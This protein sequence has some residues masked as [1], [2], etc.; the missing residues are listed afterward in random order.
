M[1]SIT[2]IKLI[3]GSQALQ[4]E[5]AH[6]M[7]SLPAYCESHMPASLSANEREGRRQPAILPGVSAMH[8]PHSEELPH[9]LSPRPHHLLV[10]ADAQLLA[11]DDAGALGPGLVLVVGVLLQVNLAEARLLLI[12]R[13]FLLVCHGLPARP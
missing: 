10:L 6:R 1:S 11:V 5:L 13:L 12:E 2:P 7:E 8:L 3:R 9:L 4:Q